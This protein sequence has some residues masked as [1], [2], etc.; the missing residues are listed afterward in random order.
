MSTLLSSLTQYSILAVATCALA[1]HLVFNR[2]EPTEL[3]VVAAALLGPPA[4]FSSLPVHYYGILGGI[5]LSYATFYATLA[6]SVF[7]Y[8]ISPFHPLARYPGPFLAKVS[9]GYW[10]SIAIRGRQHVE[11]QQLHNIY[12]D[13]VRFGPNE[14]SFRDTSMI[15]P[16]MCAHGMPKGPMFE[17]R[18]LKPPVRAFSTAALEEYEPIVAKRGAQLV[19]IL[20]EKKTVDFGYWVNFLSLRLSFHPWRSAIWL[21]LIQSFDIMT[22]ALF[23]G[24]LGAEMMA[25]EDKDGVMHSFKLGFESGQ[26]FEHLPW[27]GFWMRQFP[28]LA[29]SARNYRAMCIERGTRRYQHGSKQKDLFYYLSNED[30]SEKQTPDKATILADSSLAITAGSDTTAS[31]EVDQFYPPEENSLDPKYH[32]QMPY[33]E[34]AINETMRLFPAILSGSQRS[35]E[36][37]SG[38]AAVG[39][40]FIP[41]NTSVRVHFWSVQR[42]ARNFS[43]PET[44][45]PERWL[46]AEGVEDAR[47]AALGLT[48]GSLTHNVNAFT[49]FST[50]PWNCVG[51]NLGLLELRCVMT[52][53]MQRLSLRFQDGWDPAT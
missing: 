26:I 27:L 1:T 32:S 24:N 8:R 48:P 4:V 44:F 30:G 14:L 43:L 49:P 46:V 47:V 23:G 28:K 51:K 31:A 3:P 45:L 2:L 5:A 50:G 16:I 33:L 21:S 40:H 18:A 15:Q 52:H 19:E 36:L 10:G 12:G 13:I 17:G 34:A 42:D 39:P 22:D 11:L 38:G 9:R 35:P 41:E 29:A 25:T 20:A 53:I 6:S 37:G 7:L